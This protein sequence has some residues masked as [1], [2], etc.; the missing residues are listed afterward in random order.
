MSVDGAVIAHLRV[1]GPLREVDGV[2]R[3]VLHV[4]R[5]VE[6]A[7]VESDRSSVTLL[8][9]GTVTAVQI[10]R[11]RLPRFAADE[12]HHAADGIRSVE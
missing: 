9:V 7:L 12:V 4:G 2:N 8:V 10:D 6:P 3:G 1:V 5:R 11:P